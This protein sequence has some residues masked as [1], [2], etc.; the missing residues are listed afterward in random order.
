MKINNEEK[1]KI[2]NEYLGERFK[3][4][5]LA[6]EGAPIS[7]L[8]RDHDDKEYYIYVEIP[9]EKYVSERENTGIAIENKHFYTL[10]GMMSQDMNV[11]WYVAFEDGFMLFYLNDSLTPEQLN[12]L[13]EQTLIGAASALHIH[14]DQIKHD[15]KDGK[16]YSTLASK[17][18]QPTV[19]QGSL[20]MQGSLPIGRKP[21]ARVSKRKK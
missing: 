13:P 21:K 5:E 6:S 11:F 3:T 17:L 1:A 7:F 10:Y 9:N 15:N 8:C 18:N 19:I 14:K 12:V 2:F 4:F 20:P 16:T